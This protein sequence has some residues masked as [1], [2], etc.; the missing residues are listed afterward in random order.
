MATMVL[1]IGKSGSGKSA[2]MRNFAPDDVKVINVLGKSL[3]FKSNGFHKVTTDDYKTVATE[4]RDAKERN[5]VIDDAGY[6]ITNMFMNGHGQKKGNA[7]FEFYSEIAT[8]FWKLLNYIKTLPQDKIVYIVMHEDTNDL[9]ETKPKTIGKMLDEKVNIQGMFTI[10]LRSMFRDGKYLFRTQ[11]SGLDVCKSPIGLF[12]N[13][14]IDNDLKMVSDKIR[15][16]YAEGVR[17]EEK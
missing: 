4:I 16:Y 6:L 9:G 11:T 10:V 8:S 2:S 3:P 13:E 12:D 14:Y 5:I 7:V 1:I 17:E 15:E